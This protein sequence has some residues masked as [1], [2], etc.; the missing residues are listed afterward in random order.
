M[1]ATIG[2]KLKKGNISRDTA[3]ADEEKRVHTLAGD[4]LLSALEIAFPITAYT[5]GVMNY[6]V[7]GPEY[8]DVL[9]NEIH[10]A[11][12]VTGGEWSVD[13]LD[14]MPRLES[15]ARETVRCD[16]TSVCKSIFP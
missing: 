16:T 2:I 12:D 6:A 4:C 13:I 11:L 10:S 1:N 3:M 5:I 15:F 14:W 7:A 8:T 9:R